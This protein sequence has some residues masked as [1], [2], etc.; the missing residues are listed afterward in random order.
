MTTETKVNYTETQTTELVQQY[1][2]GVAVEQLAEQL[3]KTVRSIVA[4]LS[5]EGVYRA[6]SKTS[7][8]RVTKAELVLELAALLDVQD[9]AVLQSLEKASSEAL[10]MLVSKISE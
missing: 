3:G 10:A 5:R 8:A 4:K 2:N 7:A 9:V 6:K 1:Q